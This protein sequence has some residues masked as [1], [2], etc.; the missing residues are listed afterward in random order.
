MYHILHLIT[1]IEAIFNRSPDKLRHMQLQLHRS[2]TIFN[3]TPRIYIF[4][5]SILSCFEM[6]NANVYT[7]K[8]CTKMYAK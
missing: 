1:K 5:K 3:L 2:P 4:L 8:L 7:H 6:H